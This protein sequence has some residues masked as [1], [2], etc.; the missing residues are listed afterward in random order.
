M[1][2]GLKNKNVLITG[3]SKNIGRAIAICLAQKK[4]NVIIC[5]R[6][7]KELEKVLKIMNRYSG[8]HHAFT[9]DLEDPNGPLELF[10]NLKD[11][12]IAPDIIIHNLGGSRQV[13]DSNFSRNDLLNV[14]Q[15]N[16]G[17]AH[18]INKELLPQMIDKNWGRIIHI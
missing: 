15:L 17:I 12:K 13:T 10:N 18:E 14:W 2:S 6:N 3:A 5:A 11:S 16:L 9:L 4:C 1:K 7:N 8:Y